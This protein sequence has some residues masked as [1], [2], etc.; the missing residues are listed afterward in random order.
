MMSSLYIGSSGLKAHGAGM[1]VVGNN[2]ANVNTVAFKQTMMMYQDMI[3]QTVSARSNGITNLA[4]SG[5]GVQL[6]ETRKIF[7]EGGFEPGSSTTDISITGIGFYGVTKN[8][9]TQYTRAGNFRFNKEGAL[10]APGD[11]NLLGHAIVNGVENPTLTPIKLDFSSTEN[12]INRMPPKAT[13]AL[14]NISH[15]GGLE[16]KSDD[17]ANPFFGMAAAWDGTANPPLSSTQYSYKE[18]IEIFD[19]NGARQTAYIYYDAAGQ[20]NG[21]QAIEYLIALDPNLDASALADSKSAGLLM[22]GT[23]SF[24]SFGQIH[25]LTAFTPPASDPSNLAAWSAAS[26]N[27]GIPQFNAHFKDA[28][29]QTVSMDFGLSLASAPS[30]TNAASANASPEQIFGTAIGATR[31]PTAT[32]KYGTSLVNVSQKNDGFAEGFL[33]DLQITSDGTIIGSYSNNQDAELYRIPL[34]R[35]TSQDGLQRDGG[36]RFTATSAAGEIQEGVAG[37]ENFGQIQEWSL[38]QSNVDYAREFATMIITQRGFQMNSKVVTTSDQML[39]KA[40]ELKR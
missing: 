8:G 14:T 28:T 4:Q 2:L 12:G 36:N 39:Q 34:F 1:N 19:S 15:L 29:P 30:F 7:T 11:W 17:P 31:S 9:E 23:M 37:T 24:N 22:A 18:S 40:L 13:T 25:N 32:T 26:F 38:E 35:F 10:L 3:S 16:N 5:A 20:S 33:R 27:N 21:S 6:G